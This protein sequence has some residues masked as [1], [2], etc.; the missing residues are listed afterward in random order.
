[1]KQ[2]LRTIGGML[3]GIIIGF[4]L[5]WLITGIA[6]NGD[7]TVNENKEID[8]L[9]L[10]GSIGLAFLFLAVCGILQ[11]ILHEAGHL[12]GGLATGYRMLSFRVFKYTL[13]ND[14]ERMR[15]KRFNIPGTLGQCLMVPSEKI[16]DNNIPYFWYNAGGVA[17]NL[18]LS[19]ASIA[20][21]RLFDF[22]AVGMAFFLMM[23]F[24]G[25]LMFIT[26]GVPL[27]INGISNDGRNILIMARQP[28][29]RLHFLNMMRAAGELSRGKRMK[30]MPREWFPDEP[31]KN[32]K[33][34][35]LL[36]NRSNC[37]AQHEDLGNLDK[38]R[39]IA[40]EIMAF[41]KKL[42]QIFAMEIGSERV[43]LE[44]MT[45]NRKEVTEQ[46][47][48]KQTQTYTK[49]NSKYSPM[50][51]AVLCAVEMIM[52]NDREKAEAHHRTIA[53]NINDYAMPGEAKTA[54]ELTEH[55]LNST[56]N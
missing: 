39:E 45:T 50:K 25:L 26:N 22:G 10:A 18:L 29:M 14:G 6:D 37:M 44:L 21:L 56:E 15:W 38:A 46:L 13:V 30:E 35:F 32:P 12:L 41:D 23:T 48:T 20:V 42:P 33:D 54:L 2:I 1:M 51:L 4:G 19:V 53:D 11:T 17:V 52:N 36:A 16:S 9:L 55:I 43:M 49:A 24:T 7:T 8:W 47:W 40:E 27:T 31:L 5:V 34:Y 3:A 28:E